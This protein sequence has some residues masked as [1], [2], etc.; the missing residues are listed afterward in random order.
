MGSFTEVV[1]NIRILVHL[2]AEKYTRTLWLLQFEC[3]VGM[4]L[5]LLARVSSL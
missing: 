5:E 4:L 1:S 2:V 3:C